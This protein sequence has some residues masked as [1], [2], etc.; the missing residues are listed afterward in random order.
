MNPCTVAKRHKWQFVKNVVTRGETLRTISMTTRGIYKC[1][2]GAKKY[3]SPQ[4]QS[5]TNEEVS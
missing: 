3:G 5:I 4:Y 2:C 1:E